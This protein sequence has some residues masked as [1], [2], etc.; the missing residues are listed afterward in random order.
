MNMINSF[1]LYA[2][3]DLVLDLLI[4]DVQVNLNGAPIM[5]QNMKGITSC[6]CQGNG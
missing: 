3:D 5:G 4:Y 6:A 2:G 1:Q